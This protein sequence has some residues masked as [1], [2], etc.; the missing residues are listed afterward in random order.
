[1]REP[2]CKVIV[3][4][5][6]CAGVL[7]GA[8]WSIIGAADPNTPPDN[9]AEAYP[10]LM[11]APDSPLHNLIQVSP[12]LYSGSEPVGS[13]AFARLKEMGV[14]TIVSVDGAP[15]DVTTAKE[16]GIRYVHVPFGYDGIGKDAAASLTR[17][18]RDIEGPV[19]VHC[20][21]GKHRGPAAAAIC[22]MADGTLDHAGGERLLKL[23][24][25]SPDY[26]GLYRDVAGFT[27]PAADAEL[28][29]LVQSAPLEPLTAAM[30]RAGRLF[31]ELT[32]R[33][34][35]KWA[36]NES[37]PDEA[38][39]HTALLLAEELRESGRNLSS[40]YGD[41]FVMLLTSAEEAAFAI[42]EQLKAGDMPAA[43]SKLMSLQ[44]ACNECHVSYRN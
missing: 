44:T 17:V 20:H 40:G 29:E 16:F 7:L 3:R 30:G 10:R 31:D 41:D 39:Q 35:A 38:P 26:A 12:R 13:E 37:R 5:V 36:Y 9:A 25:T 14:T 24:Q 15:P 2:A 33:Q 19:Y 27:P 22:A 42:S 28:P 1:M 11:E 4:T 34:K 32:A 18:M 23:A 43:D 6:G 21:H 8:I